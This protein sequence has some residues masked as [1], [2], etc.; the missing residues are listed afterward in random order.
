MRLIALLLLLSVFAVAACSSDDIKEVTLT[1]SEQGTLK[2]AELGSSELAVLGMKEHPGYVNSSVRSRFSPNMK[3]MY[4]ALYEADSGSVILVMTV[5]AYR[6]N[7]DSAV[8]SFVTDEPTE[9]GTDGKYRVLTS[10]NTL[11]VVV[12]SSDETDSELVT[13]ISNKLAQRLGLK[14]LDANKL[15]FSI[16]IRP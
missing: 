7:L 11:V 3:S 15:K 1:P 4:V 6:N 10:G 14:F 8:E 13:E 2:L 12:S 5:V 9:S 16:G